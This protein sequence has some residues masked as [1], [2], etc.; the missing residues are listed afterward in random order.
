MVSSE[1]LLEMQTCRFPHQV[2]WNLPLTRCTRSPTPPRPVRLGDPSLLRAQCSLGVSNDGWEFQGSAGRKQLSEGRPVPQGGSCT[3]ASSGERK[4]LGNKEKT[5][6]PANEGR[7]RCSRCLQYLAFLLFL[8][9]LLSTV[10]VLRGKPPWNGK[11]QEF[12]LSVPTAHLA[13][14]LLNPCLPRRAA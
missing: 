7:S 13:P 1:S 6:S 10:G 8:T 12:S 11:S 14:A 9:L 4:S 2:K 5:L 3:P